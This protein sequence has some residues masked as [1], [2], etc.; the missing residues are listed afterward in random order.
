MSEKKNALEPG[1]GIK[2]WTIQMGEPGTLFHL[3]FNPVVTFLSM[4]IIWS[5]IAYTLSRRWESY[6]EFQTW[7]HWVRG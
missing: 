3:H 4:A 6:K 5:F 2:L 7:F 1:R